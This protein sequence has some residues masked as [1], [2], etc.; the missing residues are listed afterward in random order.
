ME[1][2]MLL[3]PVDQMKIAPILFCPVNIQGR[4]LYLC[5]LVENL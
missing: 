1:F 5:D 4:E 3:R 2:V